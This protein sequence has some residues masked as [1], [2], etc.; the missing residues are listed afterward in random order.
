M[1]LNTILIKQLTTI[2]THCNPV[3]VSKD[4]E[5][6]YDIEGGMRQMINC[7]TILYHRNL[8]RTLRLKSQTKVYIY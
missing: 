7:D 6:F 8:N 1:R 3:Q 4:R 5:D 2:L